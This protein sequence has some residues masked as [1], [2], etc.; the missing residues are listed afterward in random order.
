LISQVGAG[1]TRLEVPL[2][3]AELEV[4][5]K[6]MNTNGDG[7][8]SFVGFMQAA[9]R[10]GAGVGGGGV[11]VD[12]GSA[13]AAMSGPVTSSSSPEPTQK[14]WSALKDFLS[15]GG[16]VASAGLVR[17]FEAHGGADGG[18]REREGVSPSEFLCGLHILGLPSAAWGLP[19]SPAAAV[20]EK[21]LA[22]WATKLAPGSSSSPSI[23][24]DAVL[25]ECGA[26]PLPARP[27]SS[28]RGSSVVAAADHEAALA[29]VGNLAKKVSDLEA[30]LE[31]KGT[32]G[33]TVSATD[34]TESES[35]GGGSAGGGGAELDS[36]VAAALLESAISKLLNFIK[37][38]K[39]NAV[40][41]AGVFVRQERLDKSRGIKNSAGLPIEILMAEFETLK[42]GFTPA[43]AKRFHS[44]FDSNHDGHLSLVEFTD[45]I[46][47]SV[48][49]RDSAQSEGAGEKERPKK[50]ATQKAAT[51]KGK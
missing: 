42:V 45:M 50:A 36:A 39:K 21:Q 5:L 29:L 41:A 2:E 18:G 11:G 38:D 30:R 31:S 4:W 40:A 20:T 47:S 34:T 6:S 12:G 23:T 26:A 51:Q 28:V 25:K 24:I 3:Q 44:Y 17:L 37:A 1:L 32:S 22:E 14:V 48:W 7:K 15:A 16:G 9:E 33:S 35:K 19:R 43:E 27:A 49:R 46:A 10:E 8:I 13:A